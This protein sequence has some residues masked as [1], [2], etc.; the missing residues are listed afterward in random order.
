MTHGKEERDLRF[1][2]GINT[3]TTLRR[4]QKSQLNGKDIQKEEPYIVGEN[5]TWCSHSGALYGSSS[6]S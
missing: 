6:K 1:K 4:H 2:K 3:V 5:A